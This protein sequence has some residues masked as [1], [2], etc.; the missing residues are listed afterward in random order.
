MMVVAG[1]KKLSRTCTVTSAPLRPGKSPASPTAAINQTRQRTPNPISMPVLTIGMTNLAVCSRRMRFFLK[2]RRQSQAGTTPA[3]CVGCALKVP[4]ARVRKASADQG[5]HLRRQQRFNLSDDRRRIDVV[6]G[7][8]LLGF[9]GVGKFEHSELVDAEAFRTELSRN[10]VAKAAFSKMI[11]DAQN[12]VVGFG[13]GGF[14][15]VFA[16]R[17]DAIGVDDGD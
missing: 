14:D 13:G 9:P 10:R 5:S 15:H 1:M 3:R 16:Q 6:F 17:L 2:P 12:E 7:E 11:L 8:K 4:F